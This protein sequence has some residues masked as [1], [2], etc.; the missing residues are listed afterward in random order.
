MSNDCCFVVVCLFVFN[1]LDIKKEQNERKEERTD[2]APPQSVMRS[3]AYASPHDINQKSSSTTILGRS[4]DENTHSKSSAPTT[5]TT[6][7]KQQSFDNSQKTHQQQPVSNITPSQSLQ[8]P[9]LREVMAH[10]KLSSNSQAISEQTIINSLNTNIS[11]AQNLNTFISS[12]NSASI[13]TSSALPSVKVSVTTEKVQSPEKNE[14][15]DCIKLMDDSERFYI[16]NVQK[17]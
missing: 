12:S 2:S 11:N 6:T 8:N 5:T 4:R 10:S 7:T 13:P 14:T 15:P 9:S 1:I 3:A 17:V 16:D